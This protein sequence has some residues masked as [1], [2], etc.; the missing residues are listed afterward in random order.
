MVAPLRVA[1]AGASGRLGSVVCAV[2]AELD[3]VTL[4]A[5]LGRTSEPADMLAAD[6][7]IDVSTP[8]V[9]P[10]LVRFA[11]KNGLRVLVGTSGWSAQ[12]LAELEAQVSAT[13]GAAVLVVPNF[14]VGSVVGQVLAQLAAPWFSSIEIVESHHAA[15]VDSPSGTAVRTAELMAAAR[16]GVDALVAPHPEQ[17]ARGTRVAGIPVHSVRMSGVVARQEVLLGGLGETLTIAHHTN[18]P[19]S[20]RAG[21]IAAVRWLP[22]QR[23]LTVGLEHVLGVGSRE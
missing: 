20:Y 3:D 12:R 16:L 2:L 9:S 10:E 1:V 17:P 5:R 4:V 19:E 15:K 11:V 14:S 18:S 21:I 6:L 23:G 8:E 13:P 22:G 7:L